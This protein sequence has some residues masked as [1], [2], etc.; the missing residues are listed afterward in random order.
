MS[1]LI[2]NLQSG[3]QYFGNLQCFS[4]GL[5]CHKQNETWFLVKKITGKSSLEKSNDLRVRIL[6][7]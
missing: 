4:S 7:N 6:E 2:L 1:T 3:S 5:I